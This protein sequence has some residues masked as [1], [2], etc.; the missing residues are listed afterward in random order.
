MNIVVL[1]GRASRDWEL[2]FTPNGKAVASGSIAVQKDFKN[3]E[4]KYDADFINLVA[5]GKVAEL[6][7]E[8]VKKG[9]QYTVSGSIQ[10]RNYEN[11]EGK[12]VYVTEV[13]V[14]KFDFP[15]RAKSGTT[16]TNESDPF[17]NSGKQI[18]IGDE[19]LPF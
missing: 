17:A 4:G 16:A 9:D 5:W 13:N 2:K 14:N 11:N 8:Y 3:Q 18:Q 19:D 15:V 6:L 7:A 12:R 10:T 1:S